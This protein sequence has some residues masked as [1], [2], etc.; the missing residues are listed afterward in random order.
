M[1]KVVDYGLGNVQAFL[2]ICR[3]QNIEAINART[4]DQLDGAERLILPGVGS[5]DWAMSRLNG[6][7]MR[8]K[9][10]RMVQEDKVPVLGVCVGMQMMAD[11]SEGKMTDSAAGMEPETIAVDTDRV[12]C[13]GGGGAL[14]SS[15]AT[16][17]KHTSPSR[18]PPSSSPPAR[19]EGACGS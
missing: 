3:R 8:E 18:S 6:S 9:L 5:F 17:S 11:R 2:D 7:G 4:A 12:A 19:L 15:S 14:G 10:D 13:N 1:I 16:S